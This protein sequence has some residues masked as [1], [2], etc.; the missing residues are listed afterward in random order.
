MADE[1]LYPEYPLEFVTGDYYYREI[2]IEDPDPDSLD[3]DEPDYIPRDLTGC[4]AA[5]QI[6]KDLKRD[7]EIMATL[8]VGGLGSDG[9]ITIE[10]LEEE[11]EKCIRRGGWDL[12][13]R[14]SSGKPETILGGPVHPKLDYTR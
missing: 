4:T 10:L 9:I 12:E 1:E 6:R 14:D 3:P 11:S 13:L 8:V 5:A 7:T 2:L